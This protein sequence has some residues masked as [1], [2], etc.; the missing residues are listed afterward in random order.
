VSGEGVGAEVCATAG[1]NP[2]Q[3]GHESRGRMPRGAV[4]TAGLPADELERRLGLR[5]EG[6]RL[7]REGEPTGV[8]D[9]ASAPAEPRCAEPAEAR[10]AAKARVTAAA[11]D[12]L[13][14]GTP[15][16]A[17]EAIRDALRLGEELR[18]VYFPPKRAGGSANVLLMAPEL[19]AG[20]G[21]ERFSG[22]LGAEPMR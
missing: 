11:R 10:A 3:G 13:S 22:R 17:W 6:G 2:A 8:A 4:V 7:L 20:D 12:L 14:V 9:G 19:A 18:V 1:R 16:D 5:R 21:V 15:S